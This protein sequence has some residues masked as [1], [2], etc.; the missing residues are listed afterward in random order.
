MHCSKIPDQNAGLA[1]LYVCVVFSV[2]S[3]KIDDK[4]LHSICIEISD[5]LNEPP[6]SFYLNN[7]KTLYVKQKSN[8]QK[9]KKVDIFKC[10][11]R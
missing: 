1:A 4:I 8:T 7:G 5:I 6:L 3:A 9:H 10:K 2:L 11:S